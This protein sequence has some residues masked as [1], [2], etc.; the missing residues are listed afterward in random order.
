MSAAVIWLVQSV[1][2]KCYSPLKA[3]IYANCSIEITNN[4]SATLHGSNVFS[5]SEQT[6]T[7][8]ILPYP[9]SHTFG[10][11]W[12][13]DRCVADIRGFVYVSGIA[14]PRIYYNN[15]SNIRFSLKGHDTSWAE[16]LNC[17]LYICSTA[18][19]DYNCWESVTLLWG[20]ILRSTVPVVAAPR[21]IVYLR[22]RVKSQLLGTYIIPH[23][24]STRIWKLFFLT[25]AITLVRVRS[26]LEFCNWM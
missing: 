17:N 15:T 12:L 14:T 21:K 9:C 23:C 11:I 10:I 19:S 1:F 24:N 25:P 26:S 5:W 18:R 16:N 7:P 22:L 2:Q 20:Q 3:S 4:F 8:Y 6:L 13:I